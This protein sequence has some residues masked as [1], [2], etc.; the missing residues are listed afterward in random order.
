MTDWT[1]RPLTDGQRTYAASDVEHLAEIRDHLSADLEASGSPG[2]GRGRVRSRRS[3]V[4]P[5]PSDPGDRLV[6]HQGGAAV[7]RR[8]PRHRPGDCARGAS[9]GRR[10]TD[11]P[12]RFVLPDLAVAGIAQAAPSTRAATQR[13]ARP[14]RP[15]AAGRR[16]RA[17]CSTRWSGART[18]RRSNC[19]SRRPTTSSASNARR[20]R[21]PP[22]GSPNWPSRNGSTPPLLATRADLTA[23]WPAAPDARLRHGWRAELVGEPLAKLVAGEA[24]LVFDGNGGLLLEERSGGRRS[25]D[26]L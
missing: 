7:P 24:A 2:V 18:C 14:Q 26:A 21:W 11:V 20:L 4:R 9:S 1:R 10:T 22:R 8:R 13:G 25:K 3:R 16:R 19:G 15:R 12:V 23:S 6:A 17:R 5:Q